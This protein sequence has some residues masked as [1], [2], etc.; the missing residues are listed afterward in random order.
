[1]SS[2][3]TVGLPRES[4]ISRAAIA[5]MVDTGANSS[6]AGKRA[7]RGDRRAPGEPVCP[8]EQGPARQR[9]SRRHHEGGNP[10]RYRPLVTVAAAAAL[11]AALPAHAGGVKTLDGKTTKAL[12]FSLASSPQENDTS[13]VADV[14]NAVGVK[15]PFDRPD[16]G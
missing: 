14:P 16:I 15:T 10:M 2:T 4:R 11:F 7:G 12:T 5:S 13:T 8:A 9:R 6:D 3:S 1:M